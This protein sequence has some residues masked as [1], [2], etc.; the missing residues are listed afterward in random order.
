MRDELMELP[1]GWAWTKLGE[2]CEI[3]RGGS[4]RP[5]KQFL[6]NDPDGVNWIK[7]SDASASSK[8]I[9]ETKEKIKSDGIKYSRLVNEGD[10]ILSNSMSFGRPY[11]MRT[12]GCIHDGWLVLKDKFGF[13]NR[14][15]LYY[16]LSS[17]TT[18]EQFDRLAVGSTV[19][20]LNI[21]LAKEVKVILPPMNEQKRIAAKI[22]ELN[23]RT[24]KAK[25]AL[26]AIPQL[27]DRFR[28]SVLAA[29]F[30]GD[31]TAGW[32]EQNPDVEPTSVLLERIK[33][34][35]LAESKTDKHKDSIELI[36]SYEEEYGV[37]SLPENWQYVTLEKLCRTFQYGTSAKS[38][39]E[40]KIPVLRMGNL[41]NGEIDWDN[42]V[43]TSDNDEIS[44]YSLKPGDVLFNRTNSP[45]LVGKASIYRGEYSA[46]FAGYLIKIDN[47][48]ELDSEYLNYSLNTNYAKNYCW[49][50][51]TD[52]VS[53]SNINAQKLAMFEIPFCSLQEQKEIVN[54]IR[55]LFGIIAKVEQENKKLTGKLV[56]L[57]QSIL[58][59]A[60]R[61]ELVP[62]DPNDEPASV[63]LERIRA[64]RE[65]L[66]NGKPKSSHSGKDKR[67]SKTPKGQESIPGLE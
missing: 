25:E 11:I 59:Q 51:K 33:N 15:Y 48:L 24:Q 45:E 27:C 12:S 1:K 22:E 67:K 19:R 4:P 30:R 5:I 53:Q 52:G 36:Y 63:L 66:N 40:G 47:F 61:G 57:N 17:S 10:F 32:R 35:R 9:Y 60:F 31:L 44:K 38:L 42:L 8:Y 14:D 56:N 23:D 41:Q 43:Y 20:N 29:A 62:Q 21:D 6:T 39:I 64:E 54:Q 55:S 34:R 13:F 49:K 7:I 3:A 26:E 2:L 37:E 50:V 28:Q 65:Q 46:I 16:F 18:S 58:F